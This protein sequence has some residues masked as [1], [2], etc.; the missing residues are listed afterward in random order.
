MEDKN[1]GDHID[2]TKQRFWTHA[3]QA[4]FLLFIVVAVFARYW[5]SSITASD[6]T[7]RSVFLG[8]AITTANTSHTFTY[9]MAGGTTVGSI[10]FEYCSNSPLFEI[11]CTAPI[12]MS[13]DGAL[14]TSQTGETG[15]TVDA[16]ATNLNT[17]VIKRSSPATTV[18][19]ESSYKFEG[20]INPSGTGESFYVRISAHASL[21]GT[22]VTTDR[23]SVVFVLTNNLSIGAYVPPYIAFCAGQV[24]VDN[25]ASA[26]GFDLDM[27]ALSN[28]NPA[29]QTTQLAGATNSIDG[30]TVYVL[31]FTLTAGTN[32]I[33]AMASAAASTIGTSQFGI[34]ARA[35]SS[36]SIGQEPSGTGTLQPIADYNTPNTFKYVNGDAIARSTTPT[37]YNTLTISYVANSSVT[38][39]AGVY[40]TT[41]T[42]VA[43]S[44]F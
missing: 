30:Y 22:G 26:T 24:V 32:V 33:P 3:L 19:G 16:T 40:T 14:L 20:I 39:P 42:Y 4:V 29:T 18:A 27:G 11:P 9:T 8:S 5:Q 36:P 2:I 10:K 21:D 6:M 23:G 35:N 7:N 1:Q 34:N 28:T 25:C 44:T 13:A 37:D 15:F 41:L 17:I 38:Q 31:G 12:D 43:T